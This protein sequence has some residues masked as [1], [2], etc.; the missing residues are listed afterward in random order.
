MRVRVDF[1]AA[2]FGLTL[3]SQSAFAAPPHAVVELFTSQ[4]CSSCPPADAVLVDLA[5]RPDVI[6]LTFPVDYWDY[7]GWKDTLAQPSFAARQRAY[8]HLRG[9]RQ[10]Y[11]PQ[12]IVNGDK[13]C[14]GSDRAQIERHVMPGGSDHAPLA[15]DVTLAEQG[16]QVRITVTG[17]AGSSAIVWLVPV[18]RSQ[19]VKIGRGEN[20]GRTVT[21]ANVVRGMT[22][23][24]DWNGGEGQFEAP[25]SLAGE[26]DGYVVLVQAA[27]GVKPGRILGAAKS[28]GL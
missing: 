12:L 21:Y 9:D 5:A 22:R 10:V 8:A 13:P 28:A 25:L 16:G 27:R 15:A 6:A 23:V 14:L 24:G 3:F 11:T 4:G 26:S 17:S 20:H 19:T 18:L 7:L 1:I 2:A